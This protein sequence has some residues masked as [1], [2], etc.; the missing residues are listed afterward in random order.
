MWGGI[1]LLPLLS[2]ICRDFAGRGRA[3]A[4]MTRGTYHG[5][6]GSYEMALLSLLAYGL[7]LLRGLLVRLFI[8]LISI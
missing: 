2:P 8:E 5:S 1:Y 3:A 7:Y 6:G 4:M